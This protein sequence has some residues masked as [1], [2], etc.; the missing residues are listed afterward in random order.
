MEGR[1]RFVSQLKGIV[2]HEGSGLA[3]CALRKPKE[4]N[5]GAQLFFFLL[6]IHFEPPPLDDAVYIQGV[7]SLLS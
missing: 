3:A 4:A 5:A 6:V 2:C 7:S 1:V